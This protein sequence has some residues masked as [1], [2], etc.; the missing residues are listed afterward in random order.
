M[1]SSRSTST[2]RSGP[3]H[4]SSQRTRTRVVLS[5]FA[6]GLAPTN[7]YP[8]LCPCGKF[9]L[10]MPVIAARSFHAVDPVYEHGTKYIA[11]TEETGHVSRVSHVPSKACTPCLVCKGIVYVRVHVRVRVRVLV[12]VL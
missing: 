9:S 2:N 3:A 8:L 12:R 1:T 5:H 7:F 6:S 10:R 11:S 4:L